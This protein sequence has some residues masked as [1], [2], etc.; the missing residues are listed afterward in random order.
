MGFS[1][2]HLHST[3]SMLDG[4]ASIRDIITRAKELGHSAVAITDHGSTSGL[5]EAQKIGKEL[6]FKVILGT[7]FYYERENDG[8]NGHLVVLAKNNE[9]L[10]NIFK[11]QEYAYVDNFYRKPR[12]NFDKLVEHKEGLIVLSACLASTISQYI[13]NGEISEATGWARS[14]AKEFGDDFYL[15]IQP[16]AIAEQLEVNKAILRISKQLNIKTVATNDV[17]YVLE[18]DAFSHEVLLAL[19]FNKKMDDEKR[20]KFPTNDFWLRSKEEMINSF[21]GLEHKDVVDALVVTEEIVNK[22]N[23]SITTGK[24][25]PQ[26]FDI[27]EGSTPRK[28]LVK[29]VMQGATRTGLINNTSYMKEVQHEVNVIDEEGYSDYFLVVQD[30]VNSARARGETVGDGRGSAAGSKV[31]YLTDITRIEPSQFNLLFE[32]F[33]SPGR[34]PDIDSDFSNQEAVFKDLQSKY[35]EANVAKI[36]T[37]GTMTP[38]AVCRKVMSTFG[39]P[40]YI[41][42]KISKLIPDLCPSLKVAY[43]SSPELLKV[44]KEFKLEFSVIEK[45]EG[46][47]SHEGQHAGGIVLYPNLSSYLPIKTIAEDRSKRIIAVDMT[48]VEDIGFYKY[49]VLGLDTIEVIHRTLNSIEGL[50]DEDIDLY[51]IDY[52]DTKVY[53]MLCKG[54]V[55]G[56]FQL[57]AQAQKVMEQCPKNFNDLIA[58][59]ALIRPG[60]GDWQ[61][62]IDRRNGKEWTIH[63][64][65]ISYM[66]DTFGTMTY[67]EQ[68]LLDAKTFAGWGIAYA[69]KHIRKNRNIKEDSQLKAK[70]I[71]ES[72]ERGYE[73][74]DMEVVW[75]E[76]EASVGSYSFNKSHSASYAM[77][78]FQTAWLKLYYPEH[79]YASLMSVEEDQGK[80]GAYIAE[81]K[82]KGIKILPPHINESREDFVVTTEGINYRITAIAH[83]GDSAIKAINKLRPIESFDDLMERRIKKDIK[84]NTLQNLVKSG[85]F[86]FDNPNRAEL[87]WR[88]DMMNRTKTEVKNEIECKKYKDDDVTKATWEKETLGVY[89]TQHPLEKYGF[90]SL[91]EFREGEYALQGGE[92]SK[93]S[94]I[95]DK[96]NK[97]MAFIMVDTLFGVIKV[98]VFAT[99]WA[100]EELQALC[101][102]G[103]IA[104]IKGKK[105]GNGILLNEMEVLEWK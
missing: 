76:I 19:Q 15:E 88:I 13:M 25:L 54:D 14:F 69:D 17:H 101:K 41:A 53:E 35:G 89:L 60:I 5:W 12:I 61:E 77:T 32:R 84:A 67:Q 81:C 36:V 68:F 37:F 31:S 74:E 7:E 59:N 80:I 24:Y 103:N 92:I 50:L 79:F 62:Y 72:V 42:N 97:E 48:M 51:K 94:L 98:I 55:S 30:Y 56:V 95:R 90:K 34:T 39:H 64:D 46:M 86:D 28:E 63:P 4:M 3:Y 23:A 44:K 66:G 102:V 75:G 18:E 22:C 10:K 99:K 100:N 83:V 96:N 38:R 71:N 52:N 26:Y 93:V 11:L 65:R 33:M 49:D 82:R 40:T 27:P 104:F 58:I 47:I 57:S 87:L 20:F 1:H 45:L 105:S 29:K 21:T 43:E 9:G 6:D 73:M 8:K 85:C 2:L 91:E 16:N 78:S 70:F